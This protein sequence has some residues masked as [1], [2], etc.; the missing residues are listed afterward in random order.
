MFQRKK[1]TGKNN[2]LWKTSVLKTM[3]KIKRKPD[4]NWCRTI[5][6]L[7]CINSAFRIELHVDSIF[8]SSSYSYADYIRLYNR[9]A[10]FSIECQKLCAW[11][12]LLL[13]DTIL[14]NCIHWQRS[15]SGS[16]GGGDGVDQHVKFTPFSLVRSRMPY[17][18]YYFHQ[19]PYLSHYLFANIPIFWGIIMAISFV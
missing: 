3:R 19:K 15:N 13:S 11:W 1:K 17:S 6:R 12:W 10:L 5:K 16:G 2:E 4:Q 8:E 9:Y 14:C 7:H 18:S